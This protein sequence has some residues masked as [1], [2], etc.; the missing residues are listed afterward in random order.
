MLMCQKCFRANKALLLYPMVHSLWRDLSQ[1]Y[2]FDLVRISDDV[3]SLGWVCFVSRPYPL[4]FPVFFSF[5]RK[6]AYLRVAPKPVYQM[7]VWGTKIHMKMRLTCKWMKSHFHMKGC[8]SRLAFRKRLEVIR[9]LALHCTFDMNKIGLLWDTTQGSCPPV[10][11]Q[12]GI[13]NVLECSRFSWWKV[14]VSDL[15][16]GFPQFCVIVVVIHWLV[17]TNRESDEL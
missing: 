7:E 5:T 10:M 12:Q 8:A 15:I 2:H 17:A 14:I 13:D 1:W 11:M 6:I 3:L 16:D 9:K 4:G